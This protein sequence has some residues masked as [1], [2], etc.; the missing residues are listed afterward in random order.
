MFHLSTSIQEINQDIQSLSQP[1]L[2]PSPLLNL[3]DD[4]WKLIFF[5]LTEMNFKNLRICLLVGRKWKELTNDPLLT[6]KLIYEG[7][8]FNPSSWNKFCSPWAKIRGKKTV[9][10]EEKERAYELLPNLID[11][12]LK[13]D[14][15]AFKDKRIID[16]RNA[17]F[18]EQKNWVEGFTINGKTGFRVSKIGE[19]VV[20]ISAEYFRTKIRLFE[21]GTYTRCEET[22][23]S[24]NKLW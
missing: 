7:F 3:L 8:C 20:C 2:T 1:S 12:I 19:A 22:A 17:S 21:F 15:P 16:S 10:T 13:S 23:E 24:E 6:K 14:C 11:K 4:I 18:I 9:S 5:E